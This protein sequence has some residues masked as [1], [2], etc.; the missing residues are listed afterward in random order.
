MD[1]RFY[2]GRANDVLMTLSNNG[3]P[4]LPAS[5]TKVEFRFGSSSFNS[6]DHPSLFANEA[7]GI[8]LKFGG[9]DAPAG[10][11]D[12]TLIVYSADHPEGI[13]WGD[14]LS[15]KLEEV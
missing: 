14:P 11:H 4:V 10:L 3:S 12:M 15:I 7:N 6:V 9:M 13:V 1:A 5:I 2:K 8:R